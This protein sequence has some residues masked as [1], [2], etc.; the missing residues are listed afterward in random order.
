MTDNFGVSI[1]KKGM[2]CFRNPFVLNTLLLDRLV[3]S[4]AVVVRPCDDESVWRIRAF[5]VE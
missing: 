4:K 2:R 3:I 5:L 1:A